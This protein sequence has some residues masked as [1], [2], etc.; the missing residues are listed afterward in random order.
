MR[1][2]VVCATPRVGYS[3]RRFEAPLKEGTSG[4]LVRNMLCGGYSLPRG[5]HGSVEGGPTLL[6]SSKRTGSLFLMKYIITFFISINDRGLR[7]LRV[8]DHGTLS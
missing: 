7:G 4:D 5:W 2:A 1:D 6:G 8:F 3:P